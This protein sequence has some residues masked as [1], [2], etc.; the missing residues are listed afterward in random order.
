MSGYIEKTERKPLPV[1]PT[2]D[3]V[4]FPAV[5]LS[6]ELS[7]PSMLKAFGEASI[8][9]GRVF[10]TAQKDP[11]YDE[12]SPANLY[13]TGTVCQIKHVVKNQNGNLLV[14]FEG[15]C[16][17]K[18]ADYYNN[19]GYISADVIFMRISTSST[20]S[21]RTESIRAEIFSVIEE[22]TKL[23]S[24]VSDDFKNAAA[25]LKNPD[26]FAD[27]IASTLLV[28]YKNKQLILECL[29]PSKR[30]DKL[31]T[32]L[33]EELD[34]LQYEYDLHAKVRKR[35]DENQ[36]DYFLREQ[37]KIISQELGED[38]DECEEYRVK[39]KESKLP[40]EIESKL[41]KEVSKLEKTPYASS[42]SSVIRNYI[43]TCLDLPWN[44]STKE[45]IDIA[46]AAKILDQ[47]HCGLE[48]IKE[49]IIEY[50][51]VKQLTPCLVNQIICLVGPP[52]TGKTSIAASI[53]RALNRKYVRVSLGGIKDEA[54]IRGHRKTYVGAMPGRI[55]E[56]IGRA[57]TSNPLIVLDEL[58]KISK[59][60]NGDPSA[61]LLEVLDPEQNRFFR[62][63]FVELP[64]DLSECMFIATANSYDGIPQPLLDR[65]EII[66]LSSYTRK[67]KHD[68]VEQHFIPKQIK[69]H[70]LTKRQLKIDESAI[71]DMIDYYTREAGVRELERVIASVC[72]KTAKMIVSGERASL[73]VTAANL[74][75][76]LGRHKYIPDTLDEESEIG[77]VNGLAYTRVG[78]DLL[79]IEVSIVPGSGKIELTG[80]L[81]DVMKESARIAV[82]YLRSKCG[83]LGIDPD[84]YKNN[85]IHIHVPEGAVP[86][87][88]PSAGVTIL[89]ALTSALTGIPV[90]KDIAM[91]GEISLRGKVLPIGG[92]RE[93]TLAA[94]VGGVKEI[95]IPEKNRPNL[96]EVAS[97]VVENVQFSFCSTAEDVLSKALIFSPY[98]KADQ[99]S[100]AISIDIADKSISEIV[101][102]DK[103][104]DNRAEAR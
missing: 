35:I 104:S 5:Q 100:T 31:L 53:A 52:G 27:F 37:A 70:G 92:L 61:A 71:Y 97:E 36:R 14:T 95:F 64:F 67:E 48:K 33:H 3:N 72:R 29:N 103:S 93:K 11:S 69:R 41:L 82:S 47:D 74:E 88:G 2:R 32:L 77:V 45:R 56:A 55:I 79:K 60:L 84:F 63:H 65:M 6:I 50:L 24:A 19:E 101:S 20:D 59:T 54:D 73:S 34:I 13:K 23:N 9:N 1:I 46:E 21:V 86:K 85:D 39:I 91:T 8:G 58:D 17:A 10:I 16:R 68:I 81:G 90:R 62:D 51:A 102:N 94:Y 76:V 18:I 66:E 89:T 38:Y 22:Y 40:K 15:I 4:A 83:I 12:P 75:K 99:A 26:T 78:G 96:D 44:K 87:D 30:L 57:K 25:S 42:E 7:R 49:R 98:F 28:N 43:D 80:S